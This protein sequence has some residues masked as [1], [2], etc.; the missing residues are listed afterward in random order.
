MANVT[1]ISDYLT[2]ALIEAENNL[3]A[4]LASENF[5]RSFHDAMTV[6]LNCYKNKG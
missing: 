1:H 2:D 5:H 4:A 6:I 3:K